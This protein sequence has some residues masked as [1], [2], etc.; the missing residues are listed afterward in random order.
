MD[1]NGR[2]VVSLKSSKDTTWLPSYKSKDAATKCIKI[3]NAGIR[4]QDRRTARETIPTTL[5][6]LECILQYWLATSLY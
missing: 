6:Q 1:K 2:N 4:S 5:S 3:Q